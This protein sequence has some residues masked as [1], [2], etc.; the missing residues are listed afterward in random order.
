MWILL[1]GKKSFHKI[2]LC[3]SHVFFKMKWRCFDGLLA[4]ALHRPPIC[5]F[6]LNL[7][8]QSQV[9]PI[10]KEWNESPAH[11]VLR[12]MLSWWTNTTERWHTSCH[13]QILC[14]PI[15]C[16]MA[17]EN[18]FTAVPLIS[19]CSLHVLLPAQE[20]WQLFANPWQC[21]RRDN[22]A[23]TLWSGLIWP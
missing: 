6:R 13:L 20:D 10:L 15:K 22:L 14:V 9:D 1:V 16:L 19:L 3:H 5:M 2:V 12:H 11:R 18:N 7:C 21:Y 23:C 4:C 17:V 8:A